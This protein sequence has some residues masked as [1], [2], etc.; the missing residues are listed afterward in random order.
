M[1]VLLD[2]CDFNIRHI[3]YDIRLIY[4]TLFEGEHT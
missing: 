2:R 1:L 3:K 4:F